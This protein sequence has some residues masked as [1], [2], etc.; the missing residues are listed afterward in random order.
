MTPNDITKDADRLLRTACKIYKARLSS[1]ASADDALDAISISAICQQDAKFDAASA[2]RAAYALRDK[3]L[4]TVVAGDDEVLA[5]F[6]TDDGICYMERRTANICQRWLDRLLDIIGA[7]LS[8][9][10]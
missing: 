7:L 5:V 9:C 2:S 10:F 3:Q 1:G 6:L 4:A 8:F